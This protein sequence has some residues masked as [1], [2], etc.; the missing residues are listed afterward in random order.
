MHGRVGG[1][2]YDGATSLTSGLQGRGGTG[3]RC[4][5]WKGLIVNISEKGLIVNISVFARQTVSVTATELG[6]CSRK[7]ILDHMYVNGPG[8]MPVNLYFWTLKSGLHIV[9]VGHRLSF[10]F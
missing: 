5:D 9:F 8:G 7:A 6:R 4:R 10:F 2:R 1:D 3:V